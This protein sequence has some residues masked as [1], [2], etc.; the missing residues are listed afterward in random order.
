MN[1]NILDEIDDY[2]FIDNPY[3]PELYDICRRDV[4]N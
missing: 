3:I 2:A 1:T 4:N